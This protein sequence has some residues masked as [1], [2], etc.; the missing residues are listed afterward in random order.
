MKRPNQRHR[1]W[2]KSLR[3]IDDEDVLFRRV[4]DLPGLESAR[5]SSGYYGSCEITMRDGK[6]LVELSRE[7]KPRNG[8][9][10]EVRALFA[11]MLA[12]HRYWR[13][14]NRRARR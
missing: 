8:H 14:R 1:R 12:A 13:R 5:M 6:R 4:Y 3:R 10:Q 11:C 9:Y 7:H 2:L